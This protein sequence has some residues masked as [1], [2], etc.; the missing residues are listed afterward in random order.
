MIKTYL[1]A[2]LIPLILGSIVGLTTANNGN[3]ATLI[4]PPLTPPQIVFPIVW[5]ILYLLMGISYGRLK[6]TNKINPYLNKVYYSQLIVNL[7]WPILF[8]TLNNQLLALIWLILLDILV[9]RMVIKFYQ[10]EK[11]V[12]LIQLPYLIW[13]LFATYLNLFFFIL[14]L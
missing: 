9:L 2:I 11:W 12:G 14:N 6:T 3:F 7:I 1:K 8:F 10:E 4:K 13:T 5:T